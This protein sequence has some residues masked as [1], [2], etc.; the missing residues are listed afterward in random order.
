MHTYSFID[1]I[2]I[3][4]SASSPAGKSTNYTPSCMYFKLYLED[5]ASFM[6][7]LRVF[8]LCW[9]LEL[10]SLEK[11]LKI[12][13]SF[14]FNLAGKV[15]FEHGMER[16]II[17]KGAYGHSPSRKRRQ[18]AKFWKLSLYLAEQENEIFYIGDKRTMELN[19]YNDI[20]LP[21]VFGDKLII[22]SF[23]I[24]LIFSFSPKVCEL[25]TQRLNGIRCRYSEIYL[26]LSMRTGN[27]EI[28]MI[29]MHEIS[30]PWFH[31]FTSHYLLMWRPCCSHFKSFF[32]PAE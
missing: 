19:S 7:Q 24:H 15:T 14:W 2:P 13:R 29:V 28:V 26:V 1:W 6:E 18:K 8:K 12:K 21:K 20:R 22:S 27:Y 16:R 30:L 5:K 23:L 10:S 11:I 25:K 3:I 31:G 17:L 9:M 32:R 4:C